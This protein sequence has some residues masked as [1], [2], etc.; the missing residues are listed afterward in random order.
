MRN[1]L[2]GSLVHSKSVSILSSE[3]SEDHDFCDAT[4]LKFPPID[5]RI[6]EP[7]VD[8]GFVAGLAVRSLQNRHCFQRLLTPTSTI[9]FRL[10]G[11]HHN[12]YEGEPWTE[13]AEIIPVTMIFVE[14]VSILL[15]GK[16]RH[17]IQELR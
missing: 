15:L 4:N 11:S 6:G 16:F 9:G 12:A 7:A 2:P 13:Q 10:D 5:H 8:Q 3:E 14:T 1:R 17:N